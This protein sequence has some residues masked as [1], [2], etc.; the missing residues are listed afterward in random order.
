MVG[1]SNVKQ[2]E[3]SGKK[4]TFDKTKNI[5]I[6]M[7]SF[8]F[9]ENIIHLD[10][11]DS[12]II[13]GNPS[14]LYDE[15]VYF[16]YS[17][18]SV[19]P[20]MRFDKSGHFLNYVGRLG[21]GPEEYSEIKDVCLNKKRKLIEIL[22][23]DYVCTYD[24]SGNFVNKLSHHQSAFSFAIDEKENYWFY[25]GNNSATDD[26]KMVKMD[27]LCQNPQKL[28]R[29]KS[30]LLPMIEANF[31]KGS[32]IL[33]FKEALSHDIYAI[34]DG[35][36]EK[37]YSLY[38][39]GYYLPKKLHETPPMEVV[40]L[41]RKSNYASIL[42]CSENQEYLLL[43]LLLNKVDRDN[44]EMYYW[45]YKKSSNEDVVIS[46]DKAI[47]TDSYVYYPQFLT[48]NGK[49]YLIGFVANGENVALNTEENPAIVVV[50]VNRL[51]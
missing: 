45:I 19:N 25:L 7:S 48:E 17:R 20:A 29:E 21:N 50:D 13:D 39:P 33:T 37:N 31:G 28:L 3:V 16:I 5:K 41:L 18:G 11:S 2:E 46:L 26:A 14:L 35:N 22:S 4:L 30:T 34:A 40:D 9:P 12:T 36:L 42:Y 32:A 44:T 49:L 23:G 24:Y 38:F 15:G 47:P 27:A 10:F 1:C 51:F 6:Q 8:F 43:H